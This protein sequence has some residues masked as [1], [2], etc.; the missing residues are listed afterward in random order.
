M[1]SRDDDILARWRR[2]ARRALPDADVDLVEEVAQYA[3][4]RWMALRRQG[5]TEAD[6]DAQADA[7]LAEWAR[8]PLPERRFEHRCSAIA[9]AVVDVQHLERAAILEGS[10]DFRE[11]RKD[12][13]LLVA[14]R[15]DDGQL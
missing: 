7:D 8:R 9:A 6:A 11:Q 4:D 13:V 3:A 5:V 10:M 2:A 14:N 1:S 15:N 12:I